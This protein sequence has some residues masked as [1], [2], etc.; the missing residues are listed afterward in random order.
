MAS[1]LT[2]LTT[3]YSLLE[4]C[5]EKTAL[6]STTL[7]SFYDFNIPVASRPDLIYLRQSFETLH[8]LTLT[9]SIDTIGI[10]RF[11]P[12]HRRY[13]T[14]PGYIHLSTSPYLIPT[15]PRNTFYLQPSWQLRRRH[16]TRRLWSNSSCFPSLLQW[17]AIWQRR[18]LG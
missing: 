10:H 17:S 11:T 5:I 9:Q 12:S 1:S 2:V 7:D 15:I 16:R 14:L 18:R 8:Q 3:Y 13:I 4:L 6:R